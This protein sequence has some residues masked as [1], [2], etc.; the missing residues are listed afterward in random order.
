MNTNKNNKSNQSEDTNKMGG[1]SD[2]G[3]GNKQEKLYF[4]FNDDDDVIHTIQTDT[5]QK[6]IDS[7]DDPS[8]EESLDSQEVIKQ[9]PSQEIQEHEVNEL[10]GSTSNNT[11]ASTPFRKNTPDIKRYYSSDE[12]WKLQRN[13]LNILLKRN[14]QN[15]INQGNIGNVLNLS[16]DNYKSLDKHHDKSP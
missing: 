7:E 10:E 12:I 6:M 15:I 3:E 5:L 14:N 8:N 4:R 16:Q 9:P 2:N 13:K 11:P 1:S